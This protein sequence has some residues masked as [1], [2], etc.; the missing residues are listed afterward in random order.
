MPAPNGLVLQGGSLGLPED[1]V[2]S[3]EPNKQYTFKTS[4]YKN[5][6]T[7]TFHECKVSYIQ[8]KSTTCIFILP[9]TQQS[10]QITHGTLETLGYT[11]SMGRAGGKLPITL[12]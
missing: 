4:G 10:H 1:K 5:S 3:G 6:E 2:T 11:R 12:C 8:L 7:S 9:T